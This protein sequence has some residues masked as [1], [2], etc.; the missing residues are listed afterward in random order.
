MGISTVQCTQQGQPWCLSC[1]VRGVWR[2]GQA[3]AYASPKLQIVRIKGC[4]VAGP[5]GSLG[6]L[7]FVY[8]FL[9]K[10]AG[11]SMTF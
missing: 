11:S 1:V 10:M 8:L 4:C 7:L 5:T 9:L 3:V 6:C 2:R